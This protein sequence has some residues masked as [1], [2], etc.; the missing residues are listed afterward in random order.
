MTSVTMTS[1]SKMC[2]KNKIPCTTR[3]ARK[4]KSSSKK[5]SR[6]KKPLEEIKRANKE[7]SK[8]RAKERMEAKERAKGRKEACAKRKEDIAK[9]EEQICR[10]DIRNTRTLCLEHIRKSLIVHILRELRACNLVSESM[11]EHYSTSPSDWAQ[12]K[13]ILFTGGVR[14]SDIDTIDEEDSK[15]KKL[16]RRF[17]CSSGGSYLTSVDRLWSHYYTLMD[18]LYIPPHVL[19]ECCSSEGPPLDTFRETEWYKTYMIHLETMKS[20][21]A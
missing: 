21:K 10:S 12:T 9:G 6:D 13:R 16:S 20:R 3:G 14:L 18:E 7:R 5:V 1:D 19:R 2:L 11:I 8:E 15:P 17:T 4:M